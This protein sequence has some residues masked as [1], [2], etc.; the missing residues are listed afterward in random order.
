MVQ[1]CGACQA[2]TYRYLYSSTYMN[3]NLIITHRY[4]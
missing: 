1:Q 4:L 2:L 3:I